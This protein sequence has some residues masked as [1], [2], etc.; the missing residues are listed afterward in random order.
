MKSL[1]DYLQRFER[2]GSSDPSEQFSVVPQQALE[3]LNRH[4]LPYPI[5]FVGLFIMTAF[6]VGASEIRT[7]LNSKRIE[8]R[9]PGADHQQL[10]PDDISA[11]LETPITS[12]VTPVHRLVVGLQLARSIDFLEL[13]YTWDNGKESRVLTLSDEEP[14][15]A[16]GPRSGESQIS[17]VFAPTKGGHPFLAQANAR[18][19]A[20][21]LAPKPFWVNGKQLNGCPGPAYLACGC[22]PAS[23]PTADHRFSF[24]A[25]PLSENPDYGQHHSMVWF[26]DEAK[27][28]MQVRGAVTPTPFKRFN[29]TVPVLDRLIIINPDLDHILISYISHGAMDIQVI[30]HGVKGLQVISHSREL[31]RDL[32]GLGIRDDKAFNQNLLEIC[33]EAIEFVSLCRANVDKLNPRTPDSISTSLKSGGGALGGAVLTGGL[34]ILGI[35]AGLPMPLE[36]LMLSGAGL[37]GWFGSKKSRRRDKEKKRESTGEFLDRLLEELGASRVK[38]ESTLSSFTSSSEAEGQ[39]A[40]P[41]GSG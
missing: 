8:I 4:R 34:G 31:Q 11:L 9:A 33:Q 26:S 16:T 36:P 14:N 19:K 38:L 28:Q 18:L 1:N 32:S 30:D 41:D 13:C 17:L 10:C 25:E 3:I 40:E 20:F 29:G 27:E 5:C 6:Q 24:F 21:S 2:A 23:A 37:G 12:L 22:F 15:L 35:L 7:K 39:S